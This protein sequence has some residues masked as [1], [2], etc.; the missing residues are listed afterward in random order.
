MSKNMVQPEGPQPIWRI[1]VACWISKAT[2]AKARAHTSTYT[3]ARARTRTH[4]HTEHIILDA[5]PR[6]KFFANAPQ[7]YVLCTMAALLRRLHTPVIDRPQ[8][9]FDHWLASPD[10]SSLLWNSSGLHTLKTPSSW[11]VKWKRNHSAGELDSTDIST[12]T[13]YRCS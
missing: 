8:Y 7:C 5:F 10:I 1:R 11:A 12:E 3:R 13:P 4:T 2:R 9:T 6:Q